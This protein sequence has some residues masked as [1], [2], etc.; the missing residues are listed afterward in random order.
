MKDSPTHGLHSSSL[1]LPFLFVCSKDSPI[2]FKFERVLLTSPPIHE[3]FQALFLTAVSKV[4]IEFQEKTEGVLKI[5]DSLGERLDHFR[6]TFDPKSPN[7]GIK[8]YTK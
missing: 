2:L 5:A 4:K 7:Y 3:Y 1:F 6:L 8:K